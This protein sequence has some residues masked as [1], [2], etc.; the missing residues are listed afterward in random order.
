[1]IGQLIV[2]RFDKLKEVGDFLK[3]WKKNGLKGVD[4]SGIGI[5]SRVSENLIG[6]L[7]RIRIRI[8]NTDPNRGANINRKTKPYDK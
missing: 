8:Q 1:M 6:A 3:K 5:I 2:D 7:I 4:N